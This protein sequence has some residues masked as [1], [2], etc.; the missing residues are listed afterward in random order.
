M[1]PPARDSLRIRSAGRRQLHS[2]RKAVMSA[3]G[4]QDTAHLVI[5]QYADRHGQGA[6]AVVE[7]VNQRPAPFLHPPVTGL[8]CLLSFFTRVP[9]AEADRRGVARLGGGEGD[10]AGQAA[11]ERQEPGRCFAQKVAQLT[12]IGGDSGDLR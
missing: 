5:S 6:N 3:S 10:K 9:D 7:R 4:A 11:I 8:D 12:G 2:I 1:T